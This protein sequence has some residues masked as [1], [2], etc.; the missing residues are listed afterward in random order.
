M[1]KTVFLATAAILGGMIASSAA[2]ADATTPTAPA[3]SQYG[4]MDANGNST[5]TSPAVVHF[6][7]VSTNPDK[8]FIPDPSNPDNPKTPGEGGNTH[9][10]ALAILWAP[11]LDFGTHEISSSNQ[12]WGGQETEKDASGFVPYAQVSDQR[13]TAA[14]WS[15]HVKEDQQFMKGTTPLKGA[16]LQLKQL[17]YYDTN[18]KP[19]NT[20]AGTAKDND[21]LTEQKVM[22]APAG[23]LDGT[24]SVNFGDKL[25]DKG[26]SQ[27]IQLS[28]PGN[29]ALV[30]D[31]S[32]NL[33]W[34][35]NAAPTK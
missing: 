31:Y 29:A 22:E 28:V 20:L 11:H 7:K 35:L 25:D 14:G 10:G 23:T 8:P 21:L 2:F 24:Y 17:N 30:G 4:N 18:V 27:G 1:K 3:D 12:V 16:S 32:T 13:G 19:M 33:T 15:L 34:T 9:P 6:T 5:A 26:F